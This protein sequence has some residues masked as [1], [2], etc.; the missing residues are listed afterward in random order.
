MEQML[1]YKTEPKEIISSMICPIEWLKING[2][3]SGLANEL[4]K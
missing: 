4:S 1:E 2:M 3:P